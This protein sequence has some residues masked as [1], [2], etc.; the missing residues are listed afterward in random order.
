MYM[1]VY[2]RVFVFDLDLHSP[3]L[4]DVFARFVV[5]I[6]IDFFFLIYA[7]LFDLKLVK[8]ML[9]LSFFFYV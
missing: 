8:F 2:M 9:I 6:D 4:I 5:F 1:C 3:A 7:G